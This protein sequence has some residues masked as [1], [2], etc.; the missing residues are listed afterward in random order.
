MGEGSNATTVTLSPWVGAFYFKDNYSVILKPTGILP[1][2]ELSGTVQYNTPMVGFASH[3]K[4]SDRWYGG[5]S[6]GYGGWKVSSVDRTWDA[7]LNVGYRF[8]MGNT[9]SK[10]FAGYRY[11]YIDYQKGATE[12]E[13]DARGPY[14]GLGWDF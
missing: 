13:L 9:S 2:T 7:I 4:F 5:L 1:G 8:K 14:I 6:F 10:V 12:L 3:A 11:L